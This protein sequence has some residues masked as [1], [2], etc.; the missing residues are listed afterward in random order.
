MEKNCGG[1]RGPG[2]G[3]ESGSENPNRETTTMKGNYERKGR[4]DKV[5]LMVLLAMDG[6]EHLLRRVN[7]FGLAGRYAGSPHC[8]DRVRGH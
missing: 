5:W 6:R 2:S 3:L 8:G 4:P 7:I 1:S